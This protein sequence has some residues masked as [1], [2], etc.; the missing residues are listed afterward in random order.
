MTEDQ[1]EWIDT[2]T[3]EQLLRRWRFAAAGDLMFQ[4]E[5]GEHF[6][7]TMAQRKAEHPDPARVSKEVG[8]R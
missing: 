4:G 1:R 5:V 7:K 8:W 3:Y 2:A 6:A